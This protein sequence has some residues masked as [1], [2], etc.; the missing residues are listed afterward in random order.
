M[1]GTSN[2]DLDS[3][4]MAWK[5]SDGRVSNG[6]INRRKSKLNIFHNGVYAR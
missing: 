6:L 4:W 2:S 1:N 5:K 3:A